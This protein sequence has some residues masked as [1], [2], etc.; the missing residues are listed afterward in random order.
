MNYKQTTVSGESW[1]RANRVVIENPL[2]SIPSISFVEE[3]AI[4]IGDET[5]KKLVSNVGAEMTDPAKTFQLVNP[6]TG[7]PTGTTATYGDIYV[8]IHSLYMDLVNQ[9]DAA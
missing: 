2:N 1:V 3:K 9:R 5:I 7:L 8:M 6:A 4:N